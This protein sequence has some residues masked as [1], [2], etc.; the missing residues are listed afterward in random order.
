MKETEGQFASGGESGGVGRKAPRRKSK[1]DGG[2]S[3]KAYHGTGQ[4]GATQTGRNANAPAR[5]D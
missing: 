4:L 1:F 5:K 2:Q 3:E